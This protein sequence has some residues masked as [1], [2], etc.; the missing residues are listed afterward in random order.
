[1]SVSAG[2][3][4]FGGAGAGVGPGP[5]YA[6]PLHNAPHGPGHAVRPGPVPWP[7]RGDSD[8]ALPLYARKGSPL[9]FRFVGLQNRIIR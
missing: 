7:G 2:G 4:P 5:L 9:A 8:G 6:G 3:P 1:M